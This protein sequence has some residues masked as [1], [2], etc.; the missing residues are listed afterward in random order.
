M[1]GNCGLDRIESL[2]APLLLDHGLYFGGQCI[3]AEGFLKEIEN[4]RQTL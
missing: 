3:D 2:P 1:S 4:S